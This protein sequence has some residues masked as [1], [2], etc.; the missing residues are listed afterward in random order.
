MRDAYCTLE[1]AQSINPL[2]ANNHDGMVAG[3]DTNV[4]F[5]RHLDILARFCNWNLTFP[6]HICLSKLLESLA[7][8]TNKSRELCAMQVSRP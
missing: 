2:R 6:V 8:V 4:L 5:H 1:C 7:S 3:L